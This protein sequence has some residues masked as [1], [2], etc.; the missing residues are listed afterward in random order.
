MAT[1]RETLK[2]LHQLLLGLEEARD[3]L[4]RLP[5]QLKFRQNDVQR[6][7]G[8]LQSE[9]DALKRLR[10]DTDQKELNLKAG[11]QKLRDLR[12]KLNL[13]KAAKEFTALQ[14]EIKHVQEANARIEEE[15]LTAIT[16]QDVKAAAIAELEK[17]ATDSK[18]GLEKFS[19]EV[20]YG[21]RKWTDRVALL[22]GKIKEL[23]ATLAPDLRQEFQRHVQ[24]KGTRGLAACEDGICQN[25]FIEQS[26]QNRSEL[27]A[28]KTVRCA[29]CNAL[30]YRA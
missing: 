2:E 11:E 13:C 20:Q 6:K 15:I 23:E 12:T 26:P 14:E 29:S 28:N 25:C 19:G 16:E 7:G 5:Q 9:R 27:N 21:L 1:A 3:K 22:E 24:Q 8:V 17:T 30:L 18:D 4:Q 10:M